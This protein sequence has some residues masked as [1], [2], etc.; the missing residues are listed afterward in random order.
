MCRILHVQRR[1]IRR[2]LN[3]K[4]FNILFTYTCDFFFFK[5][6]QE[7]IYSPVIAV[8]PKIETD[9]LKWQTLATGRCEVSFALTC[10]E[11][12]GVGFS[13]PVR[14]LCLIY[15]TSHTTRLW[16]AGCALWR[17]WSPNPCSG[18]ISWIS[19]T[20]ETPQHLWTLCSNVPP[21]FFSFI[22][23]ELRFLKFIQDF[24]CRNPTSVPLFLKKQWD[25]LCKQNTRERDLA[26]AQIQ[27]CIR[28]F[29][30]HQ[31]YCAGLCFLICFGIF[32]SASKSVL[33]NS[34]I[35]NNR[36]NLIPDGW[37]TKFSWGQNLTEDGGICSRNCTFYSLCHS[38]QF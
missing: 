22:W 14:R 10:L 18:R 23:M 35:Q 28:Y 36:R 25:V 30:F 37:E 13:L 27:G 4:Y 34:S 24:F 26:G 32:G 7:N 33:I 2:K 6:K 21:P 19:S 31:L 17:L 38:H 20:V 9:I 3:R 5:W 15:F 11:L 1:E 16:K 12:P 29:Y 8:F